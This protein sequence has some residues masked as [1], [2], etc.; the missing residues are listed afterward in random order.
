MKLESRV[1][2]M[3]K[4]G[5]TLVFL[6]GWPDDGRLWGDLSKRLE[7]GGRRVFFTLPSFPTSEIADGPD[8]PELVGRLHEALDGLG[9][10]RATFIAHDWGAVL[11]YLYEAAHPERVDRLITLDVGGHFRSTGLAHTL[12]MV[13]YQWWLIAAFYLGKLLPGLGDAMTRR[14]ARLARA[15]KPEEVTSRANYPY[16]W[17]WK[18]MLL[19]GRRPGLSGYRPT[20]PV[21]FLYGQRKKYMFHSTR[22][23]ELLRGR[24]DSSRVVPVADAWHWLM[25]DQPAVVARE[26]TRWLDET[27]P[28]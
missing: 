7:I 11:G 25:V 1:E 26:I 2:V 4:P 12:F 20:R 24:G 3:Q 10:A 27:V 22:W 5:P 6:H 9:V 16:V 18:S 17:T 28:D 21:L 13:S 8:F 14:M 23:E 15:P 19:P